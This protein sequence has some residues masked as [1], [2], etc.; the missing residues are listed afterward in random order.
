MQQAGAP[1]ARPLTARS[2]WH[3]IPS[4]RR[5]RNTPHLTARWGAGPG[6]AS[7][8]WRGPWRADTACYVKVNQSGWPPALNAGYALM[9][10]VFISY[11]LASA[12]VGLL[13][14]QLVTLLVVVALPELPR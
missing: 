9:D 2:P 3:T 1:P 8:Q 11:G 7:G 10:E 12:H 6:G 14:L 5:G 13:T 4:G